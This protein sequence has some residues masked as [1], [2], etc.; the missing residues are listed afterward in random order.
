MAVRT[1][2]RHLLMS[3]SCY[4]HYFIDWHLRAAQTGGSE[5]TTPPQLLFLFKYVTTEVP[6]MTRLAHPRALSLSLHSQVTCL[7]SPRAVKPRESPKI[8][9][10][11]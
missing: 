5:L 3:G 2:E 7:N 9:A 8:P 1:W 10:I 11:R 4:F 6:Q